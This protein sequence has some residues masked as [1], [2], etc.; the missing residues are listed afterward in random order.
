MAR[1]ARVEQLGDQGGAE[2]AGAACHNHMTIA[3]I[4]GSSD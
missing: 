1:G 2:R 3:K 4:H